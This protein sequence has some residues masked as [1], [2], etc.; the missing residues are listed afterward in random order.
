M[1]IQSIGAASVA[2]YLTTA[3]LKEHGLTPEDL[4]PE[5]ALELTR[6]AC[7]EAGIDLD[8]SIEIEAYP[9]G[10]GVLVFAHIRPP[11]CYWFSFDSLDALLAA[12]RILPDAPEAAALI[13]WEGRWWLSLPGEAQQCA[14]ILSEFGHTHDRPDRLTPRLEEYGDPVFS[15]RALCEILTYFPV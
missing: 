3:D 4:S 12:A 5:R 13:W 7:G 15:S 9:G 11:Q 10:C 1:T 14:N 8:G 2:L 6:S